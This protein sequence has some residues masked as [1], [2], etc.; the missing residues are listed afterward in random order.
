MKF[1]PIVFTCDDQYFKYANV[2]ITSLVKNSN[3]ECLYEIN[4]I[5]EGISKE[6]KSISE[7]YIARHKNFTLKFIELENFNSSQFFLNSYMSASTYYRFYIPELF[8][9]YPRILYLDSD[10]IINKDIS[11]L[12]DMGFDDKLALCC[13]SP[14]IHKLIKQNNHPEFSL[15]YFTKKLK[16]E[17]PLQYFNAGV[18][19]YNIEKINEMNVGQKMFESLKEIEKPLLQDQDLLNS[20]FSRNGGV[21]L[22]DQKYNNTRIFK[23]TTM[24]MIFN[25]IMK[26]LGKTNVSQLF[27]I[28]HFVGKD[29]PWKTSRVDNSLFDYYAVK[30]PFY[31]EIIKENKT[32]LNIIKKLLFRIF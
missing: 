25:S 8:K 20:V 15:E 31:N 18:M 24:R 22:I 3:P 4:I 10:I 32:D 27:Y 11:E 1:L 7:K 13:P 30:S 17:D 2:V 26:F 23:V 6:N 12:A 14:Y 9:G 5:S 19:V 28:Y 21:K 29:K 16:M